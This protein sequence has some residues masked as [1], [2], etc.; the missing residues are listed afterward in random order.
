MANGQFDP[1]KTSP[2][3]LRRLILEK[4]RTDLQRRQVGDLDQQIHQI[5]E[6]VG[7]IPDVGLKSLA[8]RISEPGGQEMD[9]DPAKL[10]ATL[11]TEMTE[12]T[13]GRE[14]SIERTVHIAEGVHGKPAAVIDGAYD[15][16]AEDVIL[17]F[18]PRDQTQDWREFEVLTFTDPA[19]FPKNPDGSRMPNE[20]VRLRA[21]GPEGRCISCLEE[22]D[23]AVRRLNREWERVERSAQNTVTAGG[24]EEVAVREAI[25]R[26]DQALGR[27]TMLGRGTETGHVVLGTAIRLEDPSNIYDRHTV[28]HDGRPEELRRLEDAH[29]TIDSRPGL[30]KSKGDGPNIAAQKHL[31]RQQYGQII[32]SAEMRMGVPLTDDE[33]RSL[34][35]EQ[36]PGE[37]QYPGA[38]LAVDMVVRDMLPKQG[39]TNVDQNRVDDLRNIRTEVIGVLIGR[40]TTAEA[41]QAASDKGG[42]VVFI[43]QYPISP[44]HVPELPRIGCLATISE[45][46]RPEGHA[47]TFGSEYGFPMVASVQGIQ[48]IHDGDTVVV[49]DIVDKKGQ[50]VTT[51]VGP[52]D[53]LPAELG[54]SRENPVRVIIPVA[55]N[56]HE[57]AVTKDGVTLE[58][59][60]NLGSVD[61]SRIKMA[62]SCGSDGI[63]LTRMEFI[64]MGWGRCPWFHRHNHQTA[65][66]TAE[67]ELS[68][69]SRRELRNRVADSVERIIRVY[70]ERTRQLAEEYPP[71]SPER[72]IIEERIGKPKVFRVADI[73]AAGE[74]VEQVSAKLPAFVKANWGHDELANRNGM[75]FLLHERE[76][77]SSNIEDFLIPQLEGMII[78]AMRT[79]RPVEVELP[80]VMN[81]E[82]IRRLNQVKWGLIGQMQ[83]GQVEIRPGEYV[84]GAEQIARFQGNNPIPIVPLIE[85]PTAIHNLDAIISGARGPNE[86]DIDDAA[87]GT[88]DTAQRYLEVP[89][90]S[91][92]FRQEDVGVLRLYGEAIEG[93][94]RHGLSPVMCGK[95][96]ERRT[97][98]ALLVGA[99]ARK[100]SPDAQFIDDLKEMAR[101][102]E[103]SRCEDAYRTVTSKNPDGSN[104]YP[105]P[106][107]VRLKVYEIMGWGPVQQD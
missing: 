25:V 80:M 46:G 30:A 7:R 62:A 50:A 19:A 18:K 75:R 104:K 72:A 98:F 78:A 101:E 36:T 48:D 43:T 73:D 44:E 16:F 13:G 91:E 83:A 88:S 59:M 67:R 53:T 49:G 35:L 3:E 61:E 64:M 58:L 24:R 33:L 94:V 82:Q 97:I 86:V 74:G 41:R 105:T 40:D 31:R 1:D 20:M 66:Q 38:A 79:G 29:R 84:P 89:R 65:D 22:I 107:A 14:V 47:L 85:H 87:I 42:G 37:P 60:T 54:L 95:G 55:P 2:A 57:R 27:K 99:G 51:I 23:G 77:V 81:G 90:D 100:F 15:P 69:T 76:G 4:A 93:C 26:H 12:A 6:V 92:E 39:E 32:R 45:F 63:G 17:H 34:G 70:D 52:N 9:W 56:I 103:V 28:G 5:G 71:D 102:M 106:D 11:Q 10:G 21:V 96:V 68:N 8:A